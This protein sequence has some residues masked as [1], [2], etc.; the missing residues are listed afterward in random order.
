MPSWLAGT[1]STLSARI[2][3]L[4]LFASL[5][6]VVLVVYQS[7]AHREDAIAA[8]QD[9]ARHTLQSVAGNQQRLI[10]DTRQFLQRLAAMPAVHDPA[11]QACGRYLAQVLLL[12]TTYVNIGV[13]R[14]D[15]EL[16]C[17][18]RP[19]AA[20]VNVANRPYFQQ[21]ISG[22]D[23]SVGSFQIDR[24]AQVASV[25]FAYPVVPPARTKSWVRPSP[26]CRWNGG[27]C[28]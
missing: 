25:N 22:R 24:A 20:P 23:F 10:Q 1:W 27:A 6:A 11:S 26:W 13:P 4:I 18:A 17:N 5:P 15:G 8:A 2:R 28:A 3:W 19:L 9:R 21:A 16:L 7:R 12:N 14:A